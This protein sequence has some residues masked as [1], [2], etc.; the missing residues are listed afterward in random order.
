MAVFTV[1]GVIVAVL[2]ALG[3]VGFALLYAYA[4]YL[5]LPDGL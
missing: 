1:L 2:L 3:A 4:R 5:G